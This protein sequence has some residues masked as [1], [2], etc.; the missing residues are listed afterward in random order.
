MTRRLERETRQRRQCGILTIT[1]FA[2]CGFWAKTNGKTAS[3]R[4]HEDLTARLVPELG[5]DDLAIE[6]G[7]FAS[8]AY[9]EIRA[10]GTAPERVV[11]LRTAL[12]AYCKR[13]TEAMLE[14]F[15]ILR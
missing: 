3:S 4:R 9:A 12:R 1:D 2:G 6:E 5:Y 13:D 15:R 10:P 7:S 14:V 11:E 8:I